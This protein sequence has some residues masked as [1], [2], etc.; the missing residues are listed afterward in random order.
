MTLCVCVCVCVCVRVCVCV[1]IRVECTCAYV[2]VQLLPILNVSIH[3]PRSLS[4]FAAKY[5]IST[6]LPICKQNA[7]LSLLYSQLF[8]AFNS[9]SYQ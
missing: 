6:S 3:T 4:D 5:I 1:F 8:T 2:C 7:F 9:Q